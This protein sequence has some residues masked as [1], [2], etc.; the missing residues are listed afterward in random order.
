VKTE[1]IHRVGHLS[2]SGYS[3][4]IQEVAKNKDKYYN[5]VEAIETLPKYCGMKVNIIW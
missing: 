1:R 3:Q 4:Y 2:F 5:R